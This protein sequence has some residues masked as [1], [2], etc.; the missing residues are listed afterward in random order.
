[1]LRLFRINNEL[2]E[3]K[4]TVDDFNTESCFFYQDQTNQW[5]RTTKDFLLQLWV[6]FWP[7]ERGRER[8]ASLV[9]IVGRQGQWQ[10][11]LLTRVQSPVLRVAVHSRRNLVARSPQP[12]TLFDWSVICDL[13]TKPTLSGIHAAGRKLLS[14]F[15]KCVGSAV[16]RG[17]TGRGG[18]THVGSPRSALLGS[19][20]SR[21]ISVQTKQSPLEDFTDSGVFLSMP[22]AVQVHLIITGTCCSRPVWLV[23]TLTPGIYTI[24]ELHDGL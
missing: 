20:P 16:W 10:P 7:P 19:A 8:F 6:E 13:L 22:S 24:M 18:G 2:T 11:G 5:T 23:L 12:D 14:L 15:Y 4:T 3:N 1:M 17:G 9:F 21:D